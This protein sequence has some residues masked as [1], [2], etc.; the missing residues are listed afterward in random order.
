MLSNFFNGHL[1]SPSRLPSAAAQTRQNTA[2]SNYSLLFCCTN[3]G[4]FSVS[5][6]S[7]I[8]EYQTIGGEGENFYG[9]E[10]IKLNMLCKYDIF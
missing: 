5:Q 4:R 1:F 10:Y 6:A 2:E 8:E 9:I 3:C 7:I